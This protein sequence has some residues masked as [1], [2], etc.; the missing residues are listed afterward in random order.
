MTNLPAISLAS[1]HIPLVSP[2][3]ASMQPFANTMARVYAGVML[4]GVTPGV[5]PEDLPTHYKLIEDVL[6]VTS[7]QG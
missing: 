3:G 4:L 7:K 1:P 2:Y 5:A 6:N